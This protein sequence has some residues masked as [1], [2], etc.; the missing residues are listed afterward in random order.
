MRNSYV[1]LKSDFGTAPLKASTSKLE[2]FNDIM[3]DYVD[4][5]GFNEVHADNTIAYISPNF[6]GF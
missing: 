5:L 6:H 3:A 2:L 4:M 1:G